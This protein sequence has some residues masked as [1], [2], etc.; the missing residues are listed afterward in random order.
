MTTALDRL[1][2]VVAA[3]TPGEWTIDRTAYR[4][5]DSGGT[6]VDP[7]RASIDA[8]GWGGLA[9][10]VVQMKESK[11]DSPEG[12]TNAQAVVTAMRLM[13]AVA[14]PG[15]AK[16]AARQIATAMGYDYDNTFADKHAWVAA[17]GTLRG[18]FR[19]VNEPRQNDFDDA[20]VAILNLVAQTAIGGDH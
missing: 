3:A 2:D 7:W 15:I 13:R 11:F 4:D 6:A 1:R 10:V 16:K 9:N 8:P 14:D 19:D 12:A 17:R 20:A 5:T 18:R